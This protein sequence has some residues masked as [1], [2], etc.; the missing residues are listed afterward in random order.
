MFLYNSQAFAYLDPGTGG[1]IIQ[2]LI[3][4]L[5]TITF[6]FRTLITYIKSFFQKLRKFLKIKNLMTFK[7]KAENLDA[8]RKDKNFKNIFKFQ[9]FFLK[10]D[11]KKNKFKIYN[12]IKK[13]LHF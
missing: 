5:A 11:L 12:F 10:K 3:A 6:Y 9:N 8:I 2:V 4:L 1:F 13:T 7:S